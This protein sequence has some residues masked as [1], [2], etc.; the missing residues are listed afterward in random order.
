MK[1]T[2]SEL[3]FFI[4]NLVKIH[5]IRILKLILS[6]HWCKME[7]IVIASYLLPQEKL[8]ILLC[9]VAQVA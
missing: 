4:F 9:M 1:L 6:W 8:R 3:L 5:A 7:M 2:T